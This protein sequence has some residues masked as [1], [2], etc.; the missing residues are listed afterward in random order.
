[1]KRINHIAILALV[2][3]TLISCRIIH[4]D[5]SGPLVTKEFQVTPFEEIKI[6][7]AHEVYFKKSDTIKVYAVAPEKLI[8]ELKIATEGKTLKIST[9][10]AKNVIRIGYME[11]TA[12]IY[13]QAPSLAMVTVSGSGSFECSDSLKSD[14][15]NAHVTGSGEIELNNVAC[16]LATVTVTGSG[17][18]KIKTLSANQSDVTVTGSG[19]ISMDEK[20]VAKTGITVTGSGDV[21]MTF[22][23]CGEAT[24]NVSGSGDI[25]LKGTLRKLQKSVA[26]SGEI[27]TD[28]LIITQQ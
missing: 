7:G 18:I 15:F 2:C 16:N 28:K 27:E 17:E 9:Q 24:A 21:E 23:N 8:D 20:A 13:I 4:K 12:S 1:M 3:V 10:E 11:G 14:R 6:S 22:D 25:T 5:M 19:E 26:G